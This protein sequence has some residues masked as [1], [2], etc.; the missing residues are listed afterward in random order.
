[1]YKS[2][3]KTADNAVPILYYIIQINKLK[4]KQ[5]KNENNVPGHKVKF[6]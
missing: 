3:N 5:N 4:E 1:M 6:D 2:Y